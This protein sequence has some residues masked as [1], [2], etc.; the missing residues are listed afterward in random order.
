MISFIRGYYTVTVEGLDTESFLNYLIRNKIYVYNVNRMEKSKIQ[1][2]IDRN[3]YKKLKKIHRSNKFKI[4]V[5]KQTGIPFIAKRIYTYRGMVICAIISLIILMST[6]QFVTDVYITAPEGIDKTALK[7]ELYI[8]GVK[9]GVYKKSID[10]KIVRENI[11]GKFKQIAYV[12][13]NVKGT[14][15]FVNITKKDES[16]NSDENSNYCNIIAQKDGIIE[17]IVP[18]SGEAIVQEGDI[19]KKGD[20]LINGANTTAQPEVWAMTFYEAKKTSNYID[21]KNQRTGNKKNVYTI[22]FY[23]KKYKILRNIKYRDY[24]IEN[25][26]KELR[27]GDYTFPVKIT[28]STF[29]EVKKVENKIDVE[30]LKKEL[31]SKVLKQLEY[32]IPVSARILDVKD[33]Y[34]VDKSMIEYVVTVTTKEDIAK[35]DILTKSEAEAIIK[36]NIEKKNQEDGEQKISNPEKRPINDIRNEFKED[37]KSNTDDKSN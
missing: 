10:R 16:Q 34:N 21:I 24:E 9:P 28:V 37:I 8:Q 5:K 13:I 2:N 29:Y 27:I 30:K 22:S 6:S 18:R 36:S 4:K 3:N 20:V 19:V 32:T 15:I 14:N 26:I 12:S 1:F 25:N 33:K 7:K 35:L 23:D 11:M 31:S 17:K